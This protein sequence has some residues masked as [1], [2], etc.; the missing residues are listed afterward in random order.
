MNKALSILII[1][2]LFFVPIFALGQG[3]ITITNPLGSLKFEDLLNKLSTF[4]FNIALVLAPVILVF[5]GLLFVTSGGKPEQ[6]Q[7]AKNLILWTIIG[8]AIITLSRGLIAILRQ[9]LG[10]T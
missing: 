3:S 2:S 8:F 9:F 7:K 1:A 6:V 10:I 4:V 5:A